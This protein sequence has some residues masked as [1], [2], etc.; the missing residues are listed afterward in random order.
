MNLK[1]S[2]S[3]SDYIINNTLPYIP[4]PSP[5]KINSLAEK[6]TAVK[7]RLNISLSAFE[8]LSTQSSLL[9]SVIGQNFSQNI[10]NTSSTST[11][12]DIKEVINSSITDK[13]IIINNMNKDN[14]TIVNDGGWKICVISRSESER[15]RFCQ[16]TFNNPIFQNKCQKNFC[17]ECC[18][19]KIDQI[20]KNIIH[21]CKKT[22]F[23]STVASSNNDEYKNV[24]INSSNSNSNIVGYCEKMTNVNNLQKESC[25]LDMCNL[26]C[27][28]MDAMKTRIYSVDSLRR[29]YEDCNK[30]KIIF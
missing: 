4:V 5:E 10:L 11:S 20:Y 16:S 8:Y 2:L 24:C 17:T 1:L 23:K 22:C 13:E 28:T 21:I 14:N 12:I 7:S 19:A 6:I 9:Q 27:V 25:K 15:K 18:E 26:C 3:D 30:S 29:C